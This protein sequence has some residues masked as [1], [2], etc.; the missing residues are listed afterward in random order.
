[1]SAAERK[2]LLNAIQVQSKAAMRENVEALV[3]QN[4][5]VY[6]PLVRMAFS[7]CS[8][9]ST[10]P[11]KRLKDNRLDQN[12]S[13]RMPYIKWQTM[14]YGDEGS[15]KQTFESEK[16]ALASEKQLLESEKLSFA[17]TKRAFDSEKQAFEFDKKHFEKEKQVLE[18]E[19]KTFEEDKKIMEDEKQTLKSDKKIMEDEKQALESDKKIMEDEKQALEDEKQALEDE[20]QALESD[21]KIMED[22]KQALEDE[23][24]T[25]EEDKK[26]FEKEKEA[27]EKEKDVSEKLYESFEKLSSSEYEAKMRSLDLQTRALEL[28]MCQ[29]RH[30]HQK[31][32]FETDRTMQRCRIENLLEETKMIALSLKQREESATHSQIV[33]EEDL[34]LFR[35][36][37]EKKRAYHDSQLESVRKMARVQ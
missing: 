22:E 25:F 5:T 35:D 36:I 20:K 18:S 3:S 2:R 7:G 30:K 27:F 10:E 19:R 14:I 29:E 24:K 17:S 34:R 26:L 1:M 4:P 6:K 23:R 28:Q 9:K 37:A 11:T 16:Q 8:L 21:K 15:E 33:Q 31:K 32:I 12:A 13:G